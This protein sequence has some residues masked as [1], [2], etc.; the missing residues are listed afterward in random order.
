M[1]DFSLKF[2]FGWTT[3]CLSE[4][5]KPLL[6]SHLYSHTSVKT[7]VQ[8]F[9]MIQTSKFQM[10][11][12]YMANNSSS[13]SECYTGYALPQ[14]QLKHIRTPVACFCGGRDTLP[15][16]SLLLSALPKDKLVLVHMEEKYEHLDFMW[17]KDLAQK[18]Y[19]KI[20]ALMDKHANNLKA[21]DSYE[22]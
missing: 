5:E 17:A 19:P 20:L 6:Y 22:L 10:F 21:E 11:D 12:D 14:Y 13:A 4:S 3:E 2:L 1:I 16:T 18:V 7:V 9:Q 15:Q 8:W